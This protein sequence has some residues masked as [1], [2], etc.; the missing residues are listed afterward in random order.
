[1]ALRVG[2]AAYGGGLDCGDTHRCVSERS[3]LRAFLEMEPILLSSMKLWRE[4]GVRGS[5]TALDKLALGSHCK[6]GF[7][8]LT[9]CDQKEPPFTRA[10]VTVAEGLGCLII[11]KLIIDTI[12]TTTT[13]Q[14]PMAPGI[15]TATAGIPKIAQHHVVISLHQHT[16]PTTTPTALTVSPV[17]HLHDQNQDNYH[18]T[19]T[20]TIVTNLSRHLQRHRHHQR[21]HHPPLPLVQSRV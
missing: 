11:V 13:S 8:S 4:S 18:D 16:L 17:S 5:T 2:R 1:M 14:A 20:A 10:A 12:I 21:S 7:S 3:P 9:L 19:N 6:S 15:V